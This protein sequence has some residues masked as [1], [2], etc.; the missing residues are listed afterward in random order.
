[1]PTA[2]PAMTPPPTLPVRGDRANFGDQSQ[3]W[4]LWEKTYKF[5]ESIALAGNVYAN[6]VD[7]LT[8][9]GN[10]A[11]SAL[12]A[13]ASESRAAQSAAAAQAVSGATKWVAGAFTA[14]AVVWSPINGQNYRA[15]AAIANST[16]DPANDSANWFALL[17]Q[18]SLPVVT[19]SAAGTYPASANVHYLLSV[20]GI[21]LQFPANPNPGDLVGF[22]NVSGVTSNTLD[23]NGKTFKG[24]GSVMYLN[25][26]AASAI[27][28]YTTAQGWIKT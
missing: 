21:N 17:L 26:K 22:T 6:A 28:K 27:L 3:A 5:P 23:P 14:G 18:Q 9:A 16:V 10:A 7:A 24:D 15:R 2:V 1:M 8:S 11:N 20:A 12:A 19:I 13:A 4:T 25:D